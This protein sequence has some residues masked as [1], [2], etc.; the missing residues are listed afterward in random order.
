MV[1][2]YDDTRRRPIEPTLHV[3][4]LRSSRNRYVD[5]SLRRSLG[6]SVDHSATLN[7]NN[8]KGRSRQILTNR[9]QTK[10]RSF[11]RAPG[12]WLCQSV[13]RVLHHSVGVAIARSRYQS[14]P[15]KTNQTRVSALIPQCFAVWGL[16]MGSNIV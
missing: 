11:T 7:H 3:Q 6:R 10:S 2:R 14:P 15:H 1:M 16:P 12:R 4:P 5:R 8:T 13:A 9:R